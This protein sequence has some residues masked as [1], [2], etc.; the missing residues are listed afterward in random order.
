MGDA[1]VIFHAKST[2]RIGRSERCGQVLGCIFQPA[3]KMSFARRKA[4][5]PHHRNRR[6][7]ARQGRR[8]TPETTAARVVLIG[9]G[10]QTK[11]R[12]DSRNIRYP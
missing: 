5:T 9:R 6:D 1:G 7:E 3:G 8:L 11:Q 10:C 12:L 2:V 4:R